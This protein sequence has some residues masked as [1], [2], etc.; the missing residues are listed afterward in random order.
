MGLKVVIKDKLAFINIA[1]CDMGDIV[2]WEGDYWIVTDEDFIVS[3]TRGQ[4]VRYHSVL[5]FPDE[6]CKEDGPMYVEKLERAVFY[7][8]DIF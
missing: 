5:G 1:D 3:L 7:P 8:Y 6:C 2:K 4:I